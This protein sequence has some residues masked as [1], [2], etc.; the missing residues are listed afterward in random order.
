MLHHLPRCYTPP[1]ATTRPRHS[2]TETDDVAAALDA[3][4]ER[5]PG[6]SRAALLRRLVQEGYRAL[7]ATAARRRLDRL[8]AV[9]KASGA[10]TGV[11]RADELQRLRDDWPA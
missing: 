4:A 3:A 11:Y 2:I 10:M 1:V 5:W 6:E 8:A 9:R 7:D